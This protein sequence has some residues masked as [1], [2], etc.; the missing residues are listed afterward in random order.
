MIILQTGLGRRER[1]RLIQVVAAV[2]D[3]MAYKAAQNTPVPPT[4]A[5]SLA[6][7]S[8]IAAIVQPASQPR[9]RRTKTAI[10]IADSKHRQTNPPTYGRAEGGWAEGQREET[11][12]AYLN[13]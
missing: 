4:V 5:A 12:P 3:D 8:V 13:A 6:T 1:R 7:A 10:C 2:D 11:A 9:L